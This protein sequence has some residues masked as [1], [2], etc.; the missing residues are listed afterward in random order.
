MTKDEA[1]IFVKNYTDGY[2]FNDT[3]WG[4]VD[5]MARLADTI[6]EQAN[7][8]EQ[9]KA[10]NEKLREA[11]TFIATISGNPKGERR[12][13]L[14]WERANE[15]LSTTIQEHIGYNPFINEDK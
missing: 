5:A 3:S 10:D 14:I 15:A 12:Y 7:I 1:L 2:K 13:D 11:L 8:I 6:A 9:L 4:A